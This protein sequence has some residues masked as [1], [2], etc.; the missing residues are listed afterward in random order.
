MGGIGIGRVDEGKRVRREVIR[1]QK[2][3][4]DR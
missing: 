4:K 3:R 2:G 1:R